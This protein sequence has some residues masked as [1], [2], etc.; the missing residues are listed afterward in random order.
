MEGESTRIVKSGRLK[1]P[2]REFP[3]RFDLNRSSGT[4]SILEI[5]LEVPY[6]TSAPPKL[7]KFKS[8]KLIQPVSFRE[9]GKAALELQ[10]ELRA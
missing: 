4:E 10:P 6:C 2:D 1:E 3:I 9:A 7:C 5:D 8:L